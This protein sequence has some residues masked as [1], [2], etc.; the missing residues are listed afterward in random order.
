MEE[1]PVASGLCEKPRVERREVVTK[2]V[3]REHLTLVQKVAARLR[4]C[5]ALPVRLYAWA[6]LLS[7]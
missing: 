7:P 3:R 4:A 6:V 2:A 5:R 1:A